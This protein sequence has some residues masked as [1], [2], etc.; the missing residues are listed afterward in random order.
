[1]SHRPKFTVDEIKYLM[2]YG[3]AIYALY[4]GLRPP[5]T[6]AQKKFLRVCKGEGRATEG[7][8]RLFILFVKSGYS[9]HD[10]P[11]LLDFA[12]KEETKNI[13]FFGEYP[14]DEEIETTWQNESAYDGNDELE[15]GEYYE[16]NEIDTWSDVSDVDMEDY[17]EYVRGR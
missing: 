1:M 9:L 3:E 7:Y 2:K 4:A 16:E 17:G 8:E 12:Q 5:R 6:C 15:E 13:I 11:R 14:L 10:L